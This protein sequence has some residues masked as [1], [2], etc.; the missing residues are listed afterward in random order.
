MVGIG[1]DGASDMTGRKSGVVA[2]LREH[3]PSLIGIHCAAHRCALTASQA[4]K[5]IPQL[6][7]Y[8]HTLTNIFY[9]FSG[10]ALRSNKLREIQLLLELPTL[11]YAQ[12]HSVRWLSME[13]AV[14]V[15]YRTYPALVVALEHEAT[16]NPAA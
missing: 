2:K 9:Y 16:S 12:V 14:E 8:S 10:S 5:Q 3:T 15:V 4:A 13:K 7:E 6:K 1:T 11:K